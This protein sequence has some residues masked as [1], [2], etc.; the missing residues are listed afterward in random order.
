M[1]QQRA[2]AC[3][4]K[5]CLHGQAREHRDQDR[6]AEHGEHVLQAEQ[7]HLGLAEDTRVVHCI[8]RVFRAHGGYLQLSHIGSSSCPFRADGGGAMLKQSSLAQLTN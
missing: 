1:E 4:Q 2:N 5:G 7:H 8:G 6:G 3:E